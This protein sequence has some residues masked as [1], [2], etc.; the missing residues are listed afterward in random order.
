M[1]YLASRH[2]EGMRCLIHIR[3]FLGCR[4]FL[5][6]DL[7]FL[8]QQN[9][10]MISYIGLNFAVTC[11]GIKRNY[12]GLLRSRTN[13]SSWSVRCMSSGSSW[14]LGIMGS[15]IGLVPPKKKTL[16]SITT[17]PWR[18]RGAGPLPNGTTSCHTPVSIGFH[19]KPVSTAISSNAKKTHSLQQPYL[20]GS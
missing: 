15:D 19:I 17:Q 12:Y 2:V 6:W 8:E 7:E 4:V 14:I 3:I 9:T 13:I 11:S 10:Y 1:L 16:L 20:P 18:R 5:K